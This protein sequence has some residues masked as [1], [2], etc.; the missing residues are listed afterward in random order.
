[1]RGGAAL[2][3][4]VSSPVGMLDPF[5]LSGGC[6]P[7]PSHSPD[8]KKWVEKGGSIHVEVDTKVWVCTNKN[9]VSVRYP[10][11]FPDFKAAGGVRQEVDIGKFDTRPRDFA[12]GG[13][14][15]PKLDENTWHHH[16]GLKTLQ[17]VDGGMHEEFTH[18][19]G[20]SVG[21]ESPAG[22]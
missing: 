3:G 7:K 12:K 11:G 10:D 20:M 17:E 4:Y 18:R 22:G 2:F 14:L 9:G 13:E 19:G 6:A 5:G 8:P 1:M 21:K 15:G 16:Q